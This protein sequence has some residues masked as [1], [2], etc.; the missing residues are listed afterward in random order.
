[1]PVPVSVLPVRARMVLSLW[2]SSHEASTEV[3]KRRGAFGGME[4]KSCGNRERDE[5][6]AAHFYEAAAR[7][8][9]CDWREDRD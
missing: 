2:I 3:I 1:M 8:G 9:G 5:K 6:S 4:G 7:D